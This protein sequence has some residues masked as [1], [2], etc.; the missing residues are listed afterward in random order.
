MYKKDCIQIFC[1]QLYTL[2]WF[3]LSGYTLLHCA[4]AWGQLNTLK[5]LIEL[6][7]DIYATTFRDENAREIANRY[8]QTECV[9][10]LDWAGNINNC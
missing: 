9:E 2:I 1:A 8:K 7:V 6:E 3:V 4:A 5:T 10:F